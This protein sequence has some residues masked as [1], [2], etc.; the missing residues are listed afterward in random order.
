MT[1][2]LYFLLSGHRG[3]AS[4]FRSNA[5][6]TPTDRHSPTPRYEFVYRDLCI[7]G[8]QFVAVCVLDFWFLSNFKIVFNAGLASQRIWAG[9]ERQSRSVIEASASE[10][11][12][13]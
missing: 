7:F 12:F 1:H 2:K 9:K 3:L 11:L 10:N 5:L 8:H 13:T 6:A 4:C